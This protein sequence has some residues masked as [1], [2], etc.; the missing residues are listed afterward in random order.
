MKAP[1]GTKRD[2][3]NHRTKAQEVKRTR[4]KQATTAAKKKRAQRNAAR[5]KLM[6]TGAV[7][8]GDGKDVDHKRGLKAGNSKGNLRVLSATKNRATGGAKSK[9]G[10]TKRKA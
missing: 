9:G 1:H 2:P 8:K 3:V 7:R 6:A 4:T 5:A 10:T